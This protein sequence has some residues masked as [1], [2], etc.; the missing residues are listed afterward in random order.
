[1]QTGVQQSQLNPKA[2]AATTWDIT[3]R[4]A[5][6]QCA[7]A[8]ANALALGDVLA[9]DGDL[10]AG[11]TTFMQALGKALGVTESINSPTF[12]LLQRYP[13]PAGGA[14]LHCDFYRLG[15]SDQTERLRPE[16]EDA[17]TLGGCIIA[18]EWAALA[19]FYAPWRTWQLTFSNHHDKRTLALAPVGFGQAEA[20]E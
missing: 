2:S 16:L 13:L 11:K 6:T 19:E 18:A 5:L 8:L 10:G 12:V 9:L 20:T 7:E 3:T 14:L 15:E 17:L 1:M 4:E